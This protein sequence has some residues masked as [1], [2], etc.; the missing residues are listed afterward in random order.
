MLKFLVVE[1]H[2]LV[3]EGICRLLKQ[4]SE[5]V[6]VVE[7]GDGEAALNTLEQD[8]S[9]DLVLIDLAMPKMDGFAALGL[10]RDRHPT[11]PVAVL[12]AYEDPPTVNR[13][14][15]NG[16]CGFIPKS[17]S[18]EEI[19]AALQDILEGQIVLPG[20]SGAEARLGLL[21][22]RKGS[23]VKVKPQDIGLT[24]RQAQ[25]LALIL[26]GLPNREIGRQLGLTEGTVKVHAT[27]VFKI[28]GVTS[29][30]EAMVAANHYRIDLGNVF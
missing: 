29:R 12:S 25:V 11:I 14:M 3:R 2:P 30:A 28:L 5:G 24:E 27:A 15:K 26:Q 7:A 1:D 22:E 10:L 23:S 19:L 4:F 9:F 17:S 13:A 18:S 8:E 16:A 21:P 6:E 20:N